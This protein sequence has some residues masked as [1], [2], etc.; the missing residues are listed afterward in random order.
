MP[1]EPSLAVLP[2]VNM[3]P[4]KENEYF[5]DGLSEELLSKLAGIRGLKVASQTSSFHFKGK[6]EPPAVIA[7]AL[8]VNHLLEGSVRRSGT[9]VRITAQLIDARDGYHRW[10]Q[11]FDREFTDIFDIQEDI[12]IAVANALQVKLAG[13]RRATPAQPGHAR[14]GSL[15]TYLTARAQIS[16]LYGKPDWV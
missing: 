2:F 5:A 15:P 1:S 7:K 6:H 3:S 8:Q 9:R 13:C 16:W 11:T 10:S 12:A 14:S 4:D